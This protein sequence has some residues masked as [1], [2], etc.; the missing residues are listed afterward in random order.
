MNLGK[1]ICKSFW[2]ATDYSLRTRDLVSVQRWGDCLK[3]TFVGA[4]GELRVD[5]FDCQGN[6]I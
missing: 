6:L 2:K 5:W 4:Y 3:V 1:R